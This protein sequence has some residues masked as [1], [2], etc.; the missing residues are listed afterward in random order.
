MFVIARIANLKELSKPI[1]SKIKQLDK[2][3]RLRKNEINIK[4]EIFILPDETLVYCGHGNE[5]TI[6]AEKSFNPFLR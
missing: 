4:N 3:K 2:I 5:T 6:K 1:S